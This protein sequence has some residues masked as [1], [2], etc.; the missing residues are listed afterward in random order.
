[1]AIVKQPQL[2]LAQN[3]L[4]CSSLARQLINEISL[5][6]MDTVVEI[7]AGRGI[8]TAEL[9]QIAHQ[10]IAVE[11]DP[12]Y[13]RLLRQRFQ[14]ADNVHVVAGDYLQYQVTERDYKLFGNIPFN[15]SA[16][17]LRKVLYTP[18]TPV[19]ACLVLQ[20]EAAGKFAGCP[21]ETQFSVLAKTRFNLRIVRSLRRT[22]FLPVPA[23]ESV[24]LRIERQ[25]V[26]LVG[27][28][29][30]VLYERFIRFGFGTWRRS[31][32]CIFRNVF[33]YKQWK[34]LSRELGFA[35]NATPTEL[36]FDQWLGLFNYYRSMVGKCT[37]AQC[38]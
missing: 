35:L 17:I 36:T 34:R 37:G 38:K 1:M 7:G 9:A 26:P 24:L 8:I 21:H 30:Q 15:R 31:L 28:E 23:V 29:D 20:R 4:H 25:K 11:I 19:E 2:F 12:V 32:K 22:D 14:N 5:N 18:P 16:A 13:V 27:V 6:R 33:S 10:V 3:F